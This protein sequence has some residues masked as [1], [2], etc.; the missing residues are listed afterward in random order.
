MPERTRCASWSHRRVLTRCSRKPSATTGTMCVPTVSCF[1]GEGGQP[2]PL[3]RSF[4]AST[5]TSGRQS[6]FDSTTTTG[7]CAAVSPRPN[8]SAPPVMSILLYSTR[9]RP[10]RA[11]ACLTMRTRMGGTATMPR[12]GCVTGRPM[13]RPS[14]S[15]SASGGRTSPSTLQRCTGTTT[16]RPR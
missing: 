7:P 2:A 11:S 14:S 12:R 3:S 16:A 9:D 6:P 15:A 5:P 10:L 4:E 13:P 1:T 8:S